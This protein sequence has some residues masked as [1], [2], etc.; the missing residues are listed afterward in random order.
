MSSSGRKYYYG[1]VIVAVSSLSLL[2][3]FGTRLSFTLFFATLVE[4]FDWSR[5]GA[6]IIFYGIVLSSLF[7]WPAPRARKI[8]G[9]GQAEPTGQVARR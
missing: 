7:L 8:T 1:R 6:A 9:Q 4:E 3:N 2:V 5:A